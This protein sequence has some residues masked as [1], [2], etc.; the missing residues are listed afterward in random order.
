ML[1]PKVCRDRFHK[2]EEA[3]PDGD[4][5]ASRPDSPVAACVE[6]GAIWIR[7]RCMLMCGGLVN[8]TDQ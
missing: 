6:F 5:V 3:S 4:G 2:L 8:T 1:F 7:N